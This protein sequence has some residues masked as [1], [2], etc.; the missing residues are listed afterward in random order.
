MGTEATKHQSLHYGCIV[1]DRAT[2]EVTHYVEKPNSYIS[3][4]INCGIYVFSLDIFSVI[5]DAFNSK[6]KEYYRYT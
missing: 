5:G 3:T 2:Q 6:Q 1:T 4:L